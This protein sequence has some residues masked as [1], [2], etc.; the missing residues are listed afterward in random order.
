MITILHVDDDHSIRE[1]VSG[2]LS[3]QLHA[4]VTTAVAGN[5]AI[6]LLKG[7]RRFDIIVSD[8]KMAD[9]SG[10]DLLKYV[11]DNNLTSFFVIFSSELAPELPKKSGKFLGIVEKLDLEKLA[12]TI[13]FGV[14]T[15]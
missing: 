9:G 13:F 15:Y 6:Q 5:S 8:Y 4:K 2:Y 7:G 3:E 1:I 11:I 10:V 14:S 12:R